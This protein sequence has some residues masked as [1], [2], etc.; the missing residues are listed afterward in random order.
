MPEIKHTFTGGKMNKDID[1]RLV[2]NGEYRDAMNIQVATTEESDV[3]TAQNIQGNRMVRIQTNLGMIELPLEAA[4][5]ATI[6]D[7][8][9]D[10]MYWF[11]WTE[12]ANYIIEYSDGNSDASFVFIDD[13]TR[14]DSN[15]DLIPSALKFSP[16]NIITGINIIDGMI[17]WTDN[18]SEPKKINIKRSKEGTQYPNHTKLVNE[19]DNLSISN[20]VDIKEK[21]ITV[22][23]KSPS[24][25]LKMEL[26]TSRIPNNKY[27]AVIDIS[28]DEGSNEDLVERIDSDGNVDVTFF[29]FSEINVEDEIVLDINKY[30]DNTGAVQ[31][32][33]SL[34]DMT[35]WG[36]LSL[37][38]K[39]VL[40]AFDENGDAPSTP[41]TSFVIRGVIS[42]YSNSNNTIT[43]RISS[44]DGFPTAPALGEDTLQYA[45]DFFDE[46]E[47]LFEFKF[48]RFSYRY[49]YEDGEYTPF[50]PFT[51]VAFVPGSFDYHPRKGYNLGMTNRLTKVKLGNIITEKTPKDVVSVDILFKEEPSPNIYII[52]TIK[53]NDDV[54][55]GTSD[56]VWDR[57]KSD[58][59]QEYFEITKET[60]NSTLPSNQLLRPWDNVPRKAL[61]QEITAS[62]VI[63]GNYVQ[64]YDIVISDQPDKKYVPTF[65]IDLVERNSNIGEYTTTRRSIKS[66]REYQ[67][68]VVFVDKYG[69]E[70]PVISNPSG[71]Y[72]TVKEDAERGQA[73]KARLRG[74]NFPKDLTHFKFFVK[75][76]SGEYYNMA[77][78][79]W[80]N[81]EDDN[82]WLAFP[83][84]DRNKI[85]I[86][87]FLILKKGTDS[88]T[89][90]KDQARYK[91]L[92]I[93][94][95]APDF[96]KTS[97][98]LSSK[99]K[100][101][102]Q[103]VFGSNV[104]NA[105]IQSE[106]EFKMAYEPFYGT[107][108]QNLHE[109]NDS[110]LYIEFQVGT[111]VSDR[112]K[113][114]SITCDFDP[115]NGPQAT[116][117]SYSVR[118]E[119]QLG[120]DV[121]FITNDP[122]GV[123][124]N[125][126]K[127][128][129][130]VNV[131]KYKVENK[132]QFDGRFFVKIYSDEVFKVNIVKSFAG[133]LDTR[134]VSE[135]RLYSMHHGTLH[136]RLHCDRV[137]HF[138]TDDRKTTDWQDRWFNWGTNVRDGDYQVG[139]Y[140]HDH[141]T[142][143]ASYF[144]RYKKLGEA[145]KTN[146]GTNNTPYSSSRFRLLHL[147]KG[148]STVHQVEY[149]ESHG[150]SNYWDYAGNLV[151]PTLTS[152]EGKEYER[153][154]E[155]GIT[156]DGH[157]PA[158]KANSS[159]K[160][161]FNS[162]ADVG[163]LIALYGG[164]YYGWTKK[165]GA[166]T[167]NWGGDHYGLATASYA[168]ELQE[169]N[170]NNKDEWHA[171][172]ASD[173][174][175]AR[176]T[177]VWFV[178]AGPYLTETLSHDLNWNEESSTFD[179]KTDDFQDSDGI[180]EISSNTF[181]MELAFGGIKTQDAI[182]INSKAGGNA[183]SAN[184]W[185]NHFNIGGWNTTSAASNNLN[186]NS[187]DDRDFVNRIA[188]SSRFKIK[189]D[190]TDSIYT[191]TGSID[192]V[193]KFRHSNYAFWGDNGEGLHD[194]NEEEE[195][196]STAEQ[197]SFNFTKNWK[198]NTIEGPTNLSGGSDLFAKHINT[199]GRIPTGAGGAR[200]FLDVCDYAGGTG[201]I[202]ATG[203][204][205]SDDLAIYVTSLEDSDGNFIHEGMALYQYQSTGQ[206]SI[207]ALST[208]F[209]S[210]GGFGKNEH[211][212]IRR[213]LDPS[214]TGA[215]Y[216]LILGG[217]K[218][219]LSLNEHT[220]L[221]STN[222]PKPGS[223]FK[224]AQVGMNGYSPNSEFNI[225]T[226]AHK[227]TDKG[228]VGA[229][230]YTLQWVDDVEPDEVLSEN[231]AIFETEPKE[232]KELDI[233][234]E[235]TGALPIKL[236]S[237]T[238]Q[239]A[240]PLG[241]YFTISGVTYTVDGYSEE[242]VTVSPNPGNNQ[243][244]S[245]VNTNIYRPD[246]LVIKTK[247]YNTNSSREV[248]FSLTLI[249]SQY[250]LPWF[251][252]FSYGNGVESNRIRDNFNLPFLSNGVK[253]S[254]TLETEYEEERRQYGLIYSGIYNSISGVNNLNQFIQAEKITKDL[255]PIYGSIQK[256]YARDSDL[257]ALCEDKI[258]QILADKDAVFEADGNSQLVSNNMVLGQTKPFS[259]E[260]GIS[261]NPESFASESYRAYFSD[262]VR[263]SI[264]RLSM[265]GLTPI[266]DAGM[267]SWFRDNLE[268]SN[269][270]IGSYDDRKGEYNVKLEIPNTMGY[271][272]NE[273]QGIRDFLNNTINK[274]NKPKEYSDNEQLL[275]E[276]ESLLSENPFDNKL[277]TYNEK[278]KGWV[279]F[280]S[281]ADMELG[282]SMANKYYTFKQGELYRHHSKDVDR[283]TFYFNYTPSSIDVML[284]DDP[285]SIKTFNTLNYEGSQSKIDKFSVE[286]KVLDFQPNTS[287]NDQDFYN[288]YSKD[289]WHVESIITDKENGRVNEFIE[290]EGKWFNSI[291]RVINID[292][293]K[294]DVSDFSFQGIGNVAD[295]DTDPSGITI[296]V[297][298]SDVE[299]TDTEPIDTEPIDTEPVDIEP[300]DIEPIDRE[301]SDR[302]P[303]VGDVEPTRVKAPPIEPTKLEDRLLNEVE[304]PDTKSDQEQEDL[305]ELE[306]EKARVAELQRRRPT[307]TRY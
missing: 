136:D 222:K 54:V 269:R 103:V 232:I 65:D 203:S 195:G 47:K 56:N 161:Y 183:T 18:E 21:H 178:D 284:N 268:L 305:K 66:L 82:I 205:I 302:E 148:S 244:P 162:A 5:V 245:G 158:W 151:T 88:D 22:I 62:R 295:I 17:F 169:G 272:P 30:L 109:V 71:N 249:S 173:R 130:E 215:F 36:D 98:T 27:T 52:D 225:N 265:D 236:N 156:P 9:N 193:G 194:L 125:N 281:F 240:F 301:P 303:T 68:G 190:P 208:Y 300:V 239:D 226:M 175:V 78:D 291:N 31:S 99:T 179:N 8:I 263:G 233:Y 95:E 86:D 187:S 307:N 217:Y 152:D 16:N 157:D 271:S 285:S 57:L 182:K 84:S 216:K 289:G 188:L 73:L 197:L 41:I 230:G 108:G 171:L 29:D 155:F 7:E 266:S 67:L 276:I 143:M 283:N 107:P 192:A 209:G 51:Q 247:L 13:K 25:P 96:I 191:I 26:E 201:G 117:A 212:V 147:G 24:T 133:G 75:E 243:Y 20:Q 42:D 280:K 154:G 207:Q 287:Y 69:R 227:T 1:E 304:E 6:P 250:T 274:V 64:N 76:T 77:M 122:A 63:Y 50:A 213:I 160:K 168:Y 228:R 15:N 297:G 275:E 32:L 174:R 132:P 38:P 146:V 131:Y 248:G 113:I 221:T 144:R 81:A 45:I 100:N 214:G 200:I 137:D 290:K 139:Y 181:S 256:L 39:V 246:N 199:I 293:T 128:T 224:F 3:A 4:T 177:E 80:Y 74:S 241:S 104:S 87:T 58:P 126:I 129:V 211:L 112:Y 55:T 34:S 206:T 138:L 12:N 101:T 198:I 123:N 176:D 251:N 231:P 119:K 116:G 298:I 210:G 97:R 184:V 60:V 70:T 254:T 292:S 91:V 134:V 44:I 33:S 299:P 153:W 294:A 259:G 306:E 278:V 163:P 288:L 296:A 19:K 28:I 257:V 219:P 140:M 121:N 220:H 49:K 180:K 135:K 89:L 124:V 141:F 223:S 111:Q 23:K 237:D 264:L 166:L 2:P 90:V 273:V 172:L 185:E 85:D 261:K 189:E 94:N 279:S 167:A 218:Y 170:G 286:N 79:R 164:T 235:A 204:T 93:E 229:V 46:E 145:S 72:R 202:T 165:H 83:S 253:V 105:P 48:P 118:L 120:N 238:V 40:Q 159:I 258:L 92:A 102:G 61:S 10:R 255:S 35:G 277:V 196:W 14:L 114:A 260:Y 43:I 270:V 142:R 252:C 186:Y 262:K 115:I 242:K 110:E 106:K 234:Y 150:V 267:K 127:S 59:N 53:P 11:V 37:E 149:D 282:V